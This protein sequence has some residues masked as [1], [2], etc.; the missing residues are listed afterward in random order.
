MK[1]IRLFVVFLL[2]LF[3]II[4]FPIASTNA[5]DF[6][7]GGYVGC[8][9]QGD[10]VA[11]YNFLKHFSYEQ[12]YW[13]VKR[14]WSTN[15]NYY[16]DAM[17]FAIFSGHGNRWSI[18]LLDGAVNLATAGGNPHRGYG[19]LD[20]EFVA[21]ES[22]SVIPCHR[23]VS[24]WYSNWVTEPKDV[25]DGLHQAL[26]FRT[27]AYASTDQYITDYFGYRVYHNYPV[28]EAW[29]DAILWRGK[30]QE[31]GSAVMHPTCDGDKYGKTAPD[32]PGTSGELKN[33]YQWFY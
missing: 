11:V 14:C 26:G 1:T 13:G 31:C 12:F 15:N 17:D 9:G 19:D 3:I 33:W 23:D 22:C 29:F 32:P 5:T 21:F 4:M 27:V 2:S 18:T 8:Q 30:P 20:C 25:F 6:E 16:V 7:E 10:D 24:D 28:W